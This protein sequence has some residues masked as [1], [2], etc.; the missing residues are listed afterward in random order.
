MPLRSPLRKR[1]ACGPGDDDA[2]WTAAIL[3]Q[4]GCIITK[5]VKGGAPCKA[6]GLEEGFRSAG[7]PRKGGPRARHGLFADE[8]GWSDAA[9]ASWCRYIGA[10]RAR[11]AARRMARH[12]A[13][14]F[15]CS[16][17]T[18]KTAM[19]MRR[20]PKYVPKT[21]MHHPSAV[22]GNNAPVSSPPSKKKL[23]SPYDP[24]TSMH[25]GCTRTSTVASSSTYTGRL[26]FLPRCFQ[27]AYCTMFVISA[28]MMATCRPWNSSTRPPGTF[29][30]TTPN[31]APTR[32][33]QHQLPMSAGTAA[34]SA[35]TLTA[36]EWCAS[37]SNA[38]AS[39]SS[40]SAGGAS[41]SRQ[42]SCGSGSSALRISSGGPMGRNALETRL[43]SRL[44]AARGEFEKA[45][46][47]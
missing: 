19:N 37:A 36:S 6:R 32:M 27:L 13:P 30:A 44:G 17:V 42:S 7:P 26:L 10:A 1:P 11:V 41:Q 28:S 33:G 35:Q 22:F 45:S 2:A 29:V 16:C 43:G 21:W 46:K 14:S 25:V 20:K 4:R 5:Y 3:N 40:A 31:R 18:S 47:N 9:A 8:G 34:S 38:P 24:M 15:L 12:L 39:E 23:S